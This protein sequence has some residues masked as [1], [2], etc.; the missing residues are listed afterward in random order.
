MLKYSNLPSYLYDFRLSHSV[1]KELRQAI[2]YFTDVHHFHY[3]WPLAVL[4]RFYGSC[5][6]NIYRAPRCLPV[7]WK[8][9]LSNHRLLCC[10]IFC[11]C[12]VLCIRKSR[13]ISFHSLESWF[14]SNYWWWYFRMTKF[15]LFREHLSLWCHLLWLI[16]TFPWLFN[17][18]VI[19]RLLTEKYLPIYVLP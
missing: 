13:L 16:F 18:R 8:E 17:T 10:V 5:S 9:V 2:W 14:L 1:I 15:H 12:F 6:P 7:S 11:S 19:L 3:L 4:T